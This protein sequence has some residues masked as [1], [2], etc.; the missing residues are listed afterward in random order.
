MGNIVKLEGSWEFSFDPVDAG[1]ID[2]WYRK[3]PSQVKKVSLPHVWNGENNDENA[4]I[5]YY[6]KEFTVDKKESPKRFFIRFGS[7]QHHAM[8]WLNGE[9]IGTHM[10]GHV[11]FDMDGSRAVKVGETNLLVVRVQSLDRQGKIL[12]HG[13][14]ELALGGPFARGPFA[15]ITGDVCLYMVGKA[16][17]RSVNVF[18]DFDAD[19]VTIEAKFW[20]PKNFQAELEYVITNPEGDA[21][22]LQKNVKLEKENGTVSLTLQLDNGKVWNLHDPLLYKVSV[23][24]AGSYP[25]EVRFGMRSAD[26][27]K[28]SFKLNHHP[29]KLKGVGY[30]WYFPLLHGIPAFDF[31]LRKDLLAIKEA[32]FNLLR[33]GGAPLPK[34]VLD[35]CDEIGLLV[36]Q[37]TTGFN[38]KSSKDGLENLKA[39]IQS[40]VDNDGHHPCVFGWVIGSENGSMVLEN[41]NKLLRFAAELDP[42]RPVFSNL[43][44]VTMDSQGGGKIDLGKVYEPIAAT[45]GPFE[46]HKLRIGF[47]VSVRTYSMLASYCSSKDGKA[48]ADGIHGSKSFWERYNYLKDDL[49]GKVMVDGLGVCAPEGL[50]EVLDASKKHASNPEYKDV[51]KLNAELAALLKDKIPAWK[52]AESFWKE[53]SSVARQG[54]SKQIEALLINPQVSG[55]LLDTWADHG[56]NFAGLVN[57]QR[58]P[59]S[60]LD[61]LKK[62]NRPIHVI[63]EAE[64]RT[65]YI[66]TSA[67]IKIHM[68]NDG[69]LGDY[70]LLLRVKGP[71]GRIW[72]QESL[73]GKAKPGV[74]LVGRFKFPVGFEKGRFTFDLN[75]SKNNKEMARTEEVFLVP[76]ES[77]LEV[78]LKEAAMIGNFPDTVSGFHNPDASVAVLADVAALSAED[79]RKRFEKASQGGTV[80][81]G[82]LSEEDARHL[83]ALKVLP[84]EIACFR[85][86]GSINGSFHYALGGPEFKDLP[87]QCVLDQTYADVMPYW[88]VEPVPAMSVSAGSITILAGGNGKSRLRW[89]ADVATMP[90][91][92]GKVIFYQFDIFGKLGKNAL[93]DALL[94]NL[95]ASATK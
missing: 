50:Q 34:A 92:K 36:L 13:A 73:P 71:N 86:S 40:L 46:S 69:H 55:Y 37:E 5:G 23:N 80:I 49:D 65:P 83:N 81:L 47:P 66:G 18:P 3:R 30:P 44:S 26:V 82:N 72:H 53:A 35:I 56:L 20:N 85:S 8:V 74:N 31:D 68:V 79:I 24:L 43:C 76:P 22:S 16:G 21:G 33:S 90:L 62:I 28:G 93:A 32:G 89:G 60:A 57:W 11:P 52:D 64:D 12:E 39:Q 6:F 94:A 51:Q 2:Q 4:H 17:I 91:G 27:E 58:K 41:G 70:G 67:A 88:S 87:S 59:K 10:G 19:R 15:G 14:A 75:L 7:I 78:C 84:A 25:V 9:E 48:V 95:I 77:K 63:A 29:V 38:Q 61:A 1:L 42:T 45:I 54:L